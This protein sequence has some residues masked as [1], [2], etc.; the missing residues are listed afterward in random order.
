MLYIDDRITGWTP[1]DNLSIRVN[2]LDSRYFKWLIAVLQGDFG[3]SNVERRDAL[4]MILERFPA[5]LKLMSMAFI[6]Q[7]LVAV[8]IGIISA[9]R[10]YSLFDYVFTMLAYTGRSIPV[11]WFGLILIIV[12]HSSLQWPWWIG[13]DWAGTAIS[14][15]RHV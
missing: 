15:Q 8:P 6:G 13:G 3:R 1:R 9:I 10:Q 14:R 11:F 4:E 12:F 7:L 5:T 2:P